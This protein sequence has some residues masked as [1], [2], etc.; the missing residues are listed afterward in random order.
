MLC[1]PGHPQATISA[2]TCRR[3]IQ[4]PHP[5]FT[6]HLGNSYIAVHL[7]GISCNLAITTELFLYLVGFCP[8]TVCSIQTPPG[9]V[10]SH[11]AYSHFAY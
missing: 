11:F 8:T 1:A 2:F 6:V 3:Y 10:S 4:I 9:A 5:V 7:K